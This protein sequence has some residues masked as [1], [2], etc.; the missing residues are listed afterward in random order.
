MK[1]I[2]A[3]RKTRQVGRCSILIRK[4]AY[5]HLLLVSNRVDLESTRRLISRA[6][7]TTSSARCKSLNCPNILFIPC[8]TNFHSERCTYEGRYEIQSI[9]IK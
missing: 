1:L 5:T 3:L 4:F 2:E 7:D 6:L 8:K 9:I